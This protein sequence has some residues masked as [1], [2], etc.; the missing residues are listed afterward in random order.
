[1]LCRYFAVFVAHSINLPSD[2]ESLKV[3]EDAAQRSSAVLIRDPS[4]LLEHADRGM[5]LGNVLLSGLFGS[6]DSREVEIKLS[7]Q[8]TDIANTRFNTAGGAPFLVITIDLDVQP[9]FREPRNDQPQYSV[10]FDAIDKDAVRA[11]ARPIADRILGALVIA[12]EADSRFDR[13]KES[14]YLVGDDGRITYSLTATFGAASLL[15]RRLSADLPERVAK[16]LLPVGS[17]RLDLSTVYSLL[18]SA[19]DGRTEPLRAF[20]AA[21]SALEIFTNKVFKTYEEIWFIGLSRGR[22]GA[23]TKH[24]ERIREVM[25]E[26]Y[27]LLDKFTVVTVVLAPDDSDGDISEFA[28]LKNARDALFHAGASDESQLPANRALT[29][30]RK[31]IRLHVERSV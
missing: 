1:M 27:R 8:V 2:D 26:K 10:C 21:W 31:Y 22:V 28:D 25:K 9:N 23:E 13:L 14:M 3:Y 19:V 11:V 30:A 6:P 7:E 4:K 17:K 29:L 16:Y 15:V 20:V 18:R 24:L 12:S 5:A